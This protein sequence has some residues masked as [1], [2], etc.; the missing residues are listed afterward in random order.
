MFAYTTNALRAIGQNITRR[1]A[2][3][4]F[5]VFSRLQDLNIFKRLHRG[6]RSKLNGK[7][8]DS[9]L[10]LPR[11]VGLPDTINDRS[12]FNTTSSNSD[13]VQQSAY[14][15]KNNI[16][17]KVP[18]QHSVNSQYVKNSVNFATVNPRS[19]NNKVGSIL[20]YVISSNIYLCTITESWLTDT[21]GSS[22]SELQSRGYKIKDHPR[23][24]GRHGGGT[25]V[26][27]KECVEKGR[28]SKCG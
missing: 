15:T 2:P 5:D 25:A 27:Y 1:S 14:Q 21:D 16:T 23:E 6:R 7:R 13:N 26:L 11:V 3:V 8:A 9:A 17:T 28:K 4:T 24:D 10:T 18:S 19:V 12:H 22:R 20:D